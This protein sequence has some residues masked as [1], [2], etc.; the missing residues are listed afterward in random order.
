[1]FLPLLRLFQCFLLFGFCSSSSISYENL[2]IA[3]VSGYG[4]MPRNVQIELQRSLIWFKNAISVRKFEKSITSTELLNV[5]PKFSWINIQT[6]EKAQDLHVNSLEFAKLLEMSNFVILIN[7]DIQKC[8]IDSELLANA[9]PLT[10]EGLNRP[11][12]AI[13]NVCQNF[14][15]SNFFDL[16]RHEILHALGFGL[17]IPFEDSIPNRYYNWWTPKGTQN[18][19]QIFMDFS[20]RAKRVVSS[21]FNCSTIFGVEADGFKKNHLNEYIFG[22]ELMT[23]NLESGQNYFSEISAAILEET[24][25]GE[26]PWYKVNR[27]YTIEESQKYWYGKNFGC[28][29]IKFS[30][31]KFLETAGNKL[32]FPFCSINNERY[33]LIT[34]T[35]K[36]RLSLKNCQQT[37]NHQTQ[38]TENGLKAFPGATFS[39]SIHRFC[40]IDKN[41][42]NIPKNH[43]IELC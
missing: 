5:Y 39:N 4:K 13:M 3:I 15:F 11:K 7:R 27:K 6:A 16:F 2:N 17:F 14:Q 29:F 1:M 21:H 42:I 25:F 31:W 12:F 34:P 40:P 36:I 9:K 28:N 32:T 8:Q 18:V 20:K 33:C 35:Y 19:S 38:I 41:F 10:P 24:Y 43:R 30:C 26:K 22:N 37:F 23:P